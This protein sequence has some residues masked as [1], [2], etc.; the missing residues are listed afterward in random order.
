MTATVLSRLDLRGCTDVA[1]R[2][3]A[4][5][6]RRGST[7]TMRS[8]S[9]REI[10]A[11]VRARGDAAVRE[12]T[13]RFDGC[14]VDDPRVPA[15]D[16][17][18]R[19]RRHAPPSC[20]PRSRSPPSAS[21]RTTRSRPTPPSPRSTATASRSGSSRSR[22]D[23]RRALRARR[24]RRLPVDGADDRDP[25]AA[26]RAC[27]ELVLCV[28]PAADGRVPDA[29]L[30]AAALVGVDEVYRV[31]GAQA[32]AALAYGTETIRPVDVIV[33]PGNRVR[34]RWPSARSRAS[35]A[36]SRSPGRRRSWSSPTARVPADFVAADLLAQAEHGPGGAAVL[37]T[38]DADRRRRHRRRARA[39]ARPTRPRRAEI[40]ATLRTGGRTVL[41]DDAV[42][43][44]DAVERDRARAPRAPHRRSRG[45]PARWCAT[46][47]RCSSGRGRPRRSAT[48]S[49]ASTTCSPPTRTARFAERAPRRHVPQARARRARHRR[50]PR[51]AR[52]ARRRASPRPRASTR[53]RASVDIRRALTVPQDAP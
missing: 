52:A 50:R 31:G 40:A 3:R 32:I 30:A 28:P 51:R 6:R 16:L 38:W 42:A 12:L 34:R 48:T 24:S 1:W 29:T 41:V 11:D 8:P 33:G 21:A 26:R 2:A 27:A 18:R 14:D 47:A 19:A 4:P 7:A 49:P 46:R 9:V 5:R 22:S 37:V 53:T 23:A 43:A 20:A 17:A 45:A 44:L 10:L 15:A 13:A 39:A 35:S 36:S 25:R